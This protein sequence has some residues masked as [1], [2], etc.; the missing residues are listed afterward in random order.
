M[1]LEK[2]KVRNFRSINEEITLNVESDLTCLIGKSESGKTNLLRSIIFGV[3]DEP[4]SL[5]HI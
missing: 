1:F 2:V 4:L 5:I 3:S